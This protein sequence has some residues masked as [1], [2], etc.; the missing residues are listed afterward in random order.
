MIPNHQS[1]IEAIHEKKKVCVR[2]Y[3]K[4]DS[5][6]LD[7]VCAPMDYGPG[8]ENQDGLNRY[9]LWDYASNSGSH[10]LG[11]VPQ[12]IVNLQVLGEVFDP[13]QV[14][15]S[16]PSWTIPRDWPSSPLPTLAPTGTATLITVAAR[17][18][19]EPAQRPEIKPAN[20]E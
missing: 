2:F 15:N 17:T 8:S 11:L 12:Q 10:V 18:V 1:F 5:G 6:V 14:E 7:R 9:W 20:Q 3:S 13:A 16:S 4:A 19:G